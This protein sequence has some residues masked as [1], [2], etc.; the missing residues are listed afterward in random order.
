MANKACMP[1]ELNVGCFHDC[2]GP[3][4]R[5]L[6]SQNGKITSQGM[7]FLLWAGSTRGSRPLREGFFLQK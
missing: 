4:T 2:L 3:R 6:S 7:S 1:K 5:C